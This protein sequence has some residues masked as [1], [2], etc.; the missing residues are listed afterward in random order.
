MNG[1]IV[2]LD[3]FQEVV[4]Y[5]YSKTRSDLVKVS[6]HDKVAHVYDYDTPS[7]QVVTSFGNHDTPS[8]QVVTLSGRSFIKLSYRTLDLATLCKNTLVA[9]VI[10][11]YL[12]KKESFPIIPVIFCLESTE[13]PPRPTEWIAN[14]NLD[15]SGLGTISNAEIRRMYKLCSD[16]ELSSEV[17]EVAKATFIFVRV[18]LPSL[19]LEEIPAPWEKEAQIWTEA[20]EQRNLGKSKSKVAST[21]LNWRKLLIDLGKAHEMSQAKKQGSSLC[22]IQ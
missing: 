16:P 21:K 22:L 1:S 9:V 14:K 19:E 10:E 7:K 8:K 11:N 15:H 4:I 17:K 2:S 20:W 3:S 6:A 5:G 13:C 18:N 12:R